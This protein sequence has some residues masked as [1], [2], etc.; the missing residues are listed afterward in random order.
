MTTAVREKNNL[1]ILYA[2]WFLLD[3]DLI[4]IAPLLVPAAEHFQASLST[5]TLALTAYLLMFGLM[6]PIY[7]NYSDS[8]GRVRVMR[9]GMAGMAGAGLL[10]A[11]A[12]N[13]TLLIVAWGVSGAFA[14]AL[15]PVTMAYVGDTVSAEERQRA[16]SGLMAVSA[17]GIGAGTVGGGLL[18]EL[19]SWRAAIAVV[20]VLALGAC[21]LYRKLPES[22]DPERRRGRGI[23]LGRVAELLKVSWFPFLV[24]FCFVEGGP[25]VGFFNFFNASLQVHGSSSVVTGLVTSSYGL[26]AVGGFLLVR[27]VH[28]RF[29][30]ATMFA[31]GTGLLLLAYASAAISQT[32]LGILAASVLSGM[33]L[34]V[35]QSTIQDWTIA[36]APEHLRGT[37]SS[38]VASAVFTGGA[39]STAIVGGLASSGDFTLLFLVAAAV[40]LPVLAVGAL[41]RIR[42]TRAQSS[43]VG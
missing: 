41:A 16:M 32:V 39:A 26:G 11:L 18:A 7:G 3:V 4:L 5:T 9:I 29:S 25:M 43:Q 15:P 20:A 22:F 33:A 23:A 10:A 34:S 12:P 31:G 17:L 24:V 13:V 1:A 40:T 6:Q 2:G 30:S 27:A 19:V 28:S 36:A 42:F 21:M 35:A 38:L 8:V 37:A 14:G